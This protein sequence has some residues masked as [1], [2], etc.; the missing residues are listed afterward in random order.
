MYKSSAKTVPN[1]VVP[2]N[3]IKY[4]RPKSANSRVFSSKKFQTQLIKRVIDREAE[5]KEFSNYSSGIA[6]TTAGA[7]FDTSVVPQGSD[8]VQRV[9]RHIKWNSIVGKLQFGTQFAN[10]AS[11]PGAYDSAVFYVILDR[12]PN[13]ATPTFANIFDTSATVT[14]TA[15]AA[16]RNT[17]QNGKRFQIL[18]TQRCSLSATGPECLDYEFYVDL[19]RYPEKDMICEFAGS[20]TA[21]ANTNSIILAYGDQLAGASTTSVGTLLTFNIKLRFVDV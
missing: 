18:H 15:F 3:M 20:A 19:S 17:A 12:Q 5:K 1:W 8:L 11:A 16:H 21:S 10:T 14:C 7:T 2:Q 13:G 6:L 4:Q 9:G